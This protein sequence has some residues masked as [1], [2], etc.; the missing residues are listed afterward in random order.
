MHQSILVFFLLAFVH[1]SVKADTA[2]TSVDWDG[3]YTGT[4]PCGSCPGIKM[5]LELTGAA[6]KTYYKLIEIYENEK[7]GTFRS[8]GTAHWHKDGSTLDLKGKDENRTIFVTEN[9]VIFLGENDKPSAGKFNEAYTLNKLKAFAGGGE[10]LLID[11][12]KVKVR[13]EGKS[14][15]VNFSGLMN[16]QH[17]TEGGHLSLTADWIIDCKS[18]TAVMP[19]INYY[20]ERFATGKLI[21]STK[22]NTN[23]AQSFAESDQDVINQVAE[24]YCHHSY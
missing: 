24:E 11:H 17:M 8:E 6:D 18:K 7:E 12:S 21:Y 5:W 10:Q 13:K 9:A 15:I 2:R 23:G 19:R 20:S 1:T 22:K 4:I 14:R 16:F 3:Y